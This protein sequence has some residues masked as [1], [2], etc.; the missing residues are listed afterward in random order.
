M[1]E[2]HPNKKRDNRIKKQLHELNTGQNIDKDELEVKFRIDRFESIM[3]FLLV[4]AAMNTKLLFNRFSFFTD[5]KY[6]PVLAGIFIGVIV[7]LVYY[8]PLKYFM[9]SRYT[10]SQIISAT[11]L[12]GILVA[13][14]NLF[15][16]EKH[17]SSISHMALFVFLWFFLVDEGV[18][19]IKN[20]TLQYN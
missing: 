16:V 9:E 17:L 10:S 11:A 8:L 18:K 7:G 20:E 5:P 6:E 1:D 19:T 14:E 13:H 15:L 12:L 3:V 4:L 2:L